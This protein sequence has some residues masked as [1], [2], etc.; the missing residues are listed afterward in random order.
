MIKEVH[1]TT[2][3]V[4]EEFQTLHR[5][6]WNSN[7]YHIVISTWLKT[8]NAILA[9]SI[10]GIPIKT[11]RNIITQFKKTG[12]TSPQPRGRHEKIYNDVLIANFLEEYLASAANASS[13][14]QELREK[15][16]EQRQQLLSPDATSPPSISYPFTVYTVDKQ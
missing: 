6:K 7:D 11:A 14:L 2:P 10:A 5:H 4:A 16:W 8:Q 15:I 13:T 1:C 3:K 12:K 9:A